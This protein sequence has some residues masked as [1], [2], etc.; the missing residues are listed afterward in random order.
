[1]PES[2]ATS[3]VF[4]QPRWKRPP[5]DAER[6]FAVALT[7]LPVMLL[8]V[9]TFQAG[10]QNPVPSWANRQVLERLKPPSLEA[11]AGPGGKLAAKRELTGMDYYSNGRQIMARGFADQVTRLQKGPGSG[12]AVCWGAVFAMTVLG[13]TFCFLGWQLRRATSALFGAA[14]LGIGA[15]ALATGSAQ[16]E[17][18]PA[19]MVAMA[20]AFLGAL[21]GWH[22]MVAVSCLQVGLMFALP[23]GVAF[24]LT[25]PRWA[26]VAAL[27]TMSLATAL[28][29]L[30]MVR[31]VLISNWAAYGGLLV[32]M[33]AVVALKTWQ[34]RPLPWEAILAIVA[35]FS[36]LGTL[37][38]YRYAGGAPA[39]D[40][41]D[42]EGG[43]EPLPRKARARAK[44]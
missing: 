5:T 15:F 17:T 20:P 14:A 28:A 13:L 42:D 26:W 19:L 10:T 38:Q 22:M 4:I 31:A 29:Y 34:N 18:V 16:M 33:A 30:F 6:I 36:V 25:E 11:T 1:M 44:A 24:A 23:V 27:V 12:P 3:G 40:D 35:F 39:G 43:D 41:D 9:F 2:N 7:V 37:T 32:A 21:I 8:I